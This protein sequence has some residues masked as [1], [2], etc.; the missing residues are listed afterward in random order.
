MQSQSTSKILNGF[1]WHFRMSFYTHT[2]TFDRQIKIL[3]R[4]GLKLKKKGKKRLLCFK[5]WTREQFGSLCDRHLFL[6]ERFSLK[7]SGESMSLPRKKVF[8]S[9]SFF[10]LMCE[11]FCGDSWVLK[12]FSSFILFFATVVFCFGACEKFHCGCASVLAHL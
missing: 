6:C 7:W 8:V 10:L 5:K 1:C 9:V 11:V 3:D 2:I 4:K 12:S